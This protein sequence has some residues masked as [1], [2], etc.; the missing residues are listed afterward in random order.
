MPSA[1]EV[2]RKLAKAAGE[3]NAAGTKYKQALKEIERLERS[4]GIAEALRA[5]EAPTRI[6]AKPSGG[7]NEATAML[8]ASDWHVEERVDPDTINGVNEFN[9]EIARRR[10][11]RFW[12][13]GNRLIKMFKQDVKIPTIVVPLLGDFISGQ[14][15]GAENAENNLLLPTDAICFAQDLLV[16]GLEYTMAEHPDS[17]IIVVGMGGNHSRTTPKTRLGGTEN[18]HSWEYLM[19]LHMATYFRHLPP[20]RITFSVPR[21][22]HHYMDIYGQTVRLHHGHRLKF[23]GGRGGL[24]T[25]TYD[26]VDKWNKTKWADLDVFGHFHQMRDG[27]NFVCNGSLI[28]YNA[29][30]ES[31]RASY[32]PPMQTLLLFD[33]KRGRTALWP[34]YLEGQK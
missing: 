15:H 20:E 16:G 27:G 34:V 24:F 30:A 6:V 28:G 4:L 11:T 14:I 12:T 17:Q 31:I 10:A 32:E 19:Y 29:F 9:L 22:Y 33:R 5:C 23:G 26:S 3:A 8:V 21:G 7:S 2:D 18:G 25:P 13:A 1:I